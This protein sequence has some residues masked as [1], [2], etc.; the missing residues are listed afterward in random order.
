[1][2]NE[3]TLA[4]LTKLSI[5]REPLIDQLI[6]AFRDLAETVVVDNVVN[7]FSISLRLDNAGPA[8]DG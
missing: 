4:F 5:T 1:L 2:L 8:Q 7:E 6:D 3:H